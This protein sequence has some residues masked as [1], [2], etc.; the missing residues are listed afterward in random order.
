MPDGQDAVLQ[1]F[2]ESRAALLASIEGLTEAQLSAP[3]I[4]GWSAK[5]HLAHVVQMDE[6]RFFEVCRVVNGQK[7]A[8]PYETTA[9]SD[10]LNA[11]GV[12]YRRYLPMSQLLWELEYVRGLILQEVERAPEEGLDPSRYGEF[13]L[14]GGAAHEREHAATITRWRESRGL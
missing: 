2:R 1:A 4:D 5:D 10:A 13:G 14:A 11:M 8:W 12:E 7:P 3:E 6:I 9:W